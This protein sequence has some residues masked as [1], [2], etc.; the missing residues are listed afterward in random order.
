MPDAGDTMAYR[1]DNV[2]GFHRAYIS[3]G[4]MDRGQENT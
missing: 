4:K 1:E 2:P 3:T